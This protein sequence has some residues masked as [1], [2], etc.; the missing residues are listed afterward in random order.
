[1]EESVLY[2][3]LPDKPREAVIVFFGGEALFRCVNPM[4]ARLPGCECPG[5]LMGSDVVRGCLEGW[6][7]L[8][9][10]V[11]LWVDINSWW[12]AGIYRR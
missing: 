4:A 3:C 2:G 7:L 6:V 12:V 8:A 5:G 9:W 1:V 10:P 11:F